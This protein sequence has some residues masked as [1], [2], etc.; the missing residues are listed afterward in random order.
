[1]GS[2]PRLDSTTYGLLADPIP[3]KFSRL[4]ESFTGRAKGGYGRYEALLW[5]SLHA[6]HKPRQYRLGAAVLT[7]NAGNRI[8]LTGCQKRNRL[9]V[10]GLW[11]VF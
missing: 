10:Y 1:M 6:K 9:K 11:L 3:S 4:S 7:K 5:L 8:I 2:A